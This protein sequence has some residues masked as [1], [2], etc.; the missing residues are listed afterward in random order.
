MPP[1][2]PELLVAHVREGDVGLC[3][4]ERQSSLSDRLSSPN[5]LMEALAAG[6]PPLCSD[7][8]EAR[9]LLADAADEWILTDPPSMLLPALERITKAD[10][11]RFAASWRGVPSW[12][13]DVADVV[14]RVDELMAPARR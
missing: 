5:K 1:V 3:L 10:C 4:I 14:A 7:L 12:D 9:R 6:I 11:A 13:E 2:A 8:V